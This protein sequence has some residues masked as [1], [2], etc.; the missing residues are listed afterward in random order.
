MARAGDRDVGE[1]TVLV[2][3]TGADLLLELGEARP[4]LGARGG[5]APREDGQRV[6]VSAELVRQLAEADP[7]VEGGL[8][9]DAA[10]EASVSEEAAAPPTKPPRPKRKV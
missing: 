10:D 4:Q 8:G 6:G 5:A 7:A 3:L 1:A 2:E 9:S